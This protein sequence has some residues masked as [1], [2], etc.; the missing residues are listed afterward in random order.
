MAVNTYLY[1]TSTKNNS[2]VWMSLL[3]T[4]VSLK[5]RENNTL[6]KKNTR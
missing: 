3:D 5:L 4:F 6:I 2:R 1:T